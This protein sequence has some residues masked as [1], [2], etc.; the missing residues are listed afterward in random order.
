MCWPAAIPMWPKNAAWPTILIR[1]RI[2]NRFGNVSFSDV[3]A[4]PPG[5]PIRQYVYALY[6]AKSNY[7][8]YYS[9]NAENSPRP[10]RITKNSFLI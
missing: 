7:R 3:P 2:G 5:V 4:N 1:A 9:E 6:I 8:N 10:A